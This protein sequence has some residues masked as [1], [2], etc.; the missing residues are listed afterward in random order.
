MVRITVKTDQGDMSTGSSFHIGDGWL[1]TA[2]HVIKD[3][4][5]LEIFCET[6]EIALEPHNIVFP[7][8]DGI[9]L[10]LIKT[11]LIQHSQKYCTE[12]DKYIEIGGLFDDWIG[13][14]LILTKVLLMGYPQVPFSDRP[15]LIATEGEVNAVVDKYNSQHPHFIISCMGR[16]GFSG[17]PVISEHGFLIGVLTE[18]LVM[19]HQT[20]ELGFSAAL[21][22]EPLLSL[23]HSNGI[24]P[25]KN[26]EVVQDM[27]DGTEHWKK[28]AR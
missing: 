26:K 14:E 8:D 17:G 20:E 24:Y 15:I 3:L 19:N 9:D 27:F 6:H 16:G 2:A 23:L 13:D 22:V 1:V 21:S 28:S 12:D 25:G 10:A 5:I 7:E 18:S 11:D 4:E